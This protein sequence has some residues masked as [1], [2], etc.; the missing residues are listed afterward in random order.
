MRRF[1][2]TLALLTAA[3]GC[4]RPDWIQSTLVTVNVS[5]TWVGTFTGGGPSRGPMTLT[6]QQRGPKTRLQVLVHLAIDLPDPLEIPEIVQ[7]AR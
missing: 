7:A 2:L 6:L 3:G 5:G 1:V 4:A